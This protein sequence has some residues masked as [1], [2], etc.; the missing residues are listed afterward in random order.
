MVLIK[1]KQGGV[2]E[3]VVLW[4]F[5]TF[6]YF[7]FGYDIF[8]NI[9]QVIYLDS[10]TTGLMYYLGVIAPYIPIFLLMFWGYKILNPEPTFSEEGL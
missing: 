3:S 4:F 5:A 1:N 8:K 2:F 6:A 7:T 10:H 9:L